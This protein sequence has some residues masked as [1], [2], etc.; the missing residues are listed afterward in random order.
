M[1]VYEDYVEVLKV[2]SS[3]HFQAMTLVL[4]ED[5]FVWRLINVYGPVKDNQKQDFLNELEC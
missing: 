2:E 3:N 1:G 5:K 4:K